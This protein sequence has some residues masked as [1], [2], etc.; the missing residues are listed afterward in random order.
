MK[1]F[2]SCILILSIFSFQFSELM[3][4]AS[5]KINQE[6][7]AKNLCVEKDVEGSTCKG[8]CQLKKKVNEQQEQKK[9]L[10][11]LQNEKQNIDFCNQNR[12]LKLMHGSIAKVLQQRKQKA[13]SYTIHFS[14]FHPPQKTV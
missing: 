5:F 1:L 8:C 11:P 2:F 12:E 4:Y 7:I 9:E 10:P 3:I 14:I 6:Y 13:Y